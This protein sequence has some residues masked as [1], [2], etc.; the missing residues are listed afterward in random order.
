MYDPLGFI[1]PLTIPSR[2]LIQDIWKLKL[3][4]D[5]ALPKELIERWAEISKTIEDNTISFCRPYFTQGK[6]LELHVF[7]DASQSAYGAVAYLSDGN[8]STFVF[9]K[10]RVTTL[11][12]GKK[13]LTIPQAELM[14]AVV[15]TRVASSMLSVFQPLGISLNVFLWSDSQIVLYWIKKMGSVNS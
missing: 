8:S 1:S 12:T 2:M 13:M 11:K 10:S 6:I 4:W 9:S 5:D 3:D 15:G 7:V 14:A